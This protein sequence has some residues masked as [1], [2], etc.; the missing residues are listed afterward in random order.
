MLAADHQRSADVARP[1]N[2]SVLHVHRQWSPGRESLSG[3]AERT[4]AGRDKGPAPRA[5]LRQLKAI[6][7]WGRQAPQDLGRINIPVLI[8]N[9]DNDIMVPTVNSTDMARRIPGAELVIYK[10]AGHGGISQN[11][12]DFVPKALSFLGA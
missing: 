11:Y 4:E 10:D 6:K 3:S 8:A 1:K 12:A 9:G 7:A 2:L 5:F